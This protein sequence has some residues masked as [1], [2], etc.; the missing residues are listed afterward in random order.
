VPY[1]PAVLL[2]LLAVAVR[3]LPWA[4]VFSGDR[5]YFYVNDA[6]YHARRI[7]WSAEHFPAA[8]NFDPF[9]NHPHGG[10]PIWPPLF[11]GS[12]ALL[13]RLLVPAG[14][15]DAAY[16]FLA[17]LPPLLGG[18]SVVLVWAIARRHVGRGA[19]WIAGLSLALLPAHYNYSKLGYLDHHTAVSLLGTALL[20]IGMGLAALWTAEDSAPGRELRRAALMGGTLAACFL[21][22][23]GSLLYLAL[24]ELP[25][26]LQLLWV[27]APRAAARMAAA[28]ALA[29]GV[30]LL[31]L[32][33]TCMGRDWIRWGSFTPVVLSN[34]QPWLLALLAGFFAL[35]ALRLRS[36]RGAAGSGR[37]SFEAVVLG[38]ALLGISWLVVPALSTGIAD[39][40]VW[41]GREESFQA[42]VSESRPL[43]G[44]RGQIDT[45]YAVLG[46][47][48][49][50]FALPLLLAHAGYLALREAPRPPRL[51]LVFWCAALLLA[52]LFQIRFLEPLA[53]PLALV[54]GWSASAVHRELGARG[55]GGTPGAVLLVALLLAL[56]LPWLRGTC[57]PEFRR[58]V[59]ALR[60]EPIQLGAREM[61]HRMLFDVARW[62]GNNSEN[63]GDYE[64]A[65]ERPHYAVL[66]HW[67]DGHV[68]Q[69]AARRATV[70]NNFGDDIG[71]ENFELAA[72]YYLAPEPEASALLDRLGVRYVIFE[73]RLIRGRSEFD[74]DSVLARLYFQDG[75]ASRSGV[76]G[77]QGRVREYPMV[78]LRALERHRLVYESPPKSW[79]QT[80]RPGFKVY[81]HVRGARVVGW[82]TPGQ[83][84]EARLALHTPQG[85][86]PEYLAKTVADDSGRYELRLPYATRGAPPAVRVAPAYQ[87]SSGSQSGELVVDERAVREGR[88][89]SGPDLR[90]AHS[91]T[92]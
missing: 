36:A 11:D 65:R 27:R 45:E 10:E 59:D 75:A 83:E 61:R 1:V 68:I 14:D 64:A 43:L 8:L 81:E 90:P 2:F 28:L 49:L 6:Y 48:Y 44:D 73:F 5:V 15:A 69:H 18:A 24:L 26:F 20:G 54:L 30:A 58:T 34:F 7:L 57:I 63:G 87:I 92:G 40:W 17:W 50:F 55:L 77:R 51:L 74:P 31:S 56:L 82:A 71:A 78:E 53:P 62:L 13:V 37:R 80:S 76:A 4:R 85:R 66:S 41:F 19:A 22:W 70:V 42:Q 32:A 29:N 33:P 86:R 46:L 16:G 89:L 60:G 52:S 88:S 84:V 72:R 12:M 35:L 3:A 91:T 25:L 23:P 47:G 79:M 38:L 67:A 39:A 21:V 9:V